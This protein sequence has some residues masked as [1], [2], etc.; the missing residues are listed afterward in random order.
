MPN[1]G[2]SLPTPG[3]EPS[4]AKPDAVRLEEVTFQYGPTPA[5]RG[6]SL[7][8]P[9]NAFL[10]LLGPSGCGKTTLLKSIGGYL[11]P[12]AGR[13]FLRGQDVTGV[14]P[15]RRNVGMVFQNYALFPHLSAR[16]NVAFGLEVRG[17]PRTEREHRVEAMLDLVGLSPGERNRRPGA[18]SGGQQQRVAVARALAFGP[19]TLLLDE[20]L[21]NLDRYLRD[22]LRAELRR[23][24]HQAGVTTVMVTHDQNEALASSDL[25]GVMAEGKILQLGTPVEVYDR[26]RTAFVA[27][28]LGDTNLLPG[29]AFGMDLL[30][31]VMV[32]PER[33]VLGTGAVACHWW[34]AGRITTVS[35]LGADLLADVACENGPTLRVRSPRDRM[36]SA[37]DAVQVGIP[38]DAAWPIPDC[39]EPGGAPD[40][41]EHPR[42]RLSGVV[43][44]ALGSSPA[45]NDFFSR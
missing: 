45:A 35:F 21:A 11:R 18:L 3:T 34:W 37:G 26:P 20:P 36:V 29:G 7:A 1:T 43:Q 42:G 31:P 6:V 33:C 13:V 40:K 39:D 12:T 25:I 30:G 4:S 19:D 2:T 9:G 15:E 24:H 38:A 41:N 22:Q 23:L 17:L 44:T 27:R 5:V 14:P 10:T 16:R 28:F 32:R 8:V